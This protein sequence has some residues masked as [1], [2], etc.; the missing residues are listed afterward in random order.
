MSLAG[1]SW[2]ETW[3]CNALESD[4]KLT[5]VTIKDEYA[6]LNDGAKIPVQANNEDALLAIQ[7]FS[8]QPLLS[9]LLI[10]KLRNRYVYNFVQPNVTGEGKQGPCVFVD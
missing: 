8:D 2:G 4:G 9:Y 3:V 5:R 6:Q 10:D 1:V 7:T